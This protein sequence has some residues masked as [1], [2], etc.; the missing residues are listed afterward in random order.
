MRPCNIFGRTLLT[1]PPEPCNATCRL[2][3]RLSRDSASSR[4][5]QMRKSTQPPLHGTSLTPLSPILARKRT[6]VRCVSLLRSQKLRC[7]R[8][9]SA[10]IMMNSSRAF[11]NFIQQLKHAT[12]WSSRRRLQ[13]QGEFRAA[14]LLNRRA[15]ALSEQ[16]TEKVAY[17]A[18]LI[19]QSEAAEDVRA[20]RQPTS[21]YRSRL[22]RQYSVRRRPAPADPGQLAATASLFSTANTGGSHTAPGPACFVL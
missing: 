2:G 11:S 13:E 22:E 16:L 17:S 14:E 15:D 4:H 3:L 12:G 7:V 20:G 5:P 1:K 19:G 21:F 18:E 9:N 10:A 8:P 6:S